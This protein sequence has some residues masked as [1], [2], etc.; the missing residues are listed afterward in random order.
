MGEILGFPAPGLAGYLLPPGYSFAA[1]P[2]TRAD[3]ADERAYQE[4]L[5][6]LVLYV[7]C[8]Y[9]G[10]HSHPESFTCPGCG[11]PLTL[12]R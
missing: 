2:I 4:Q 7:A 10:R 11:A 12:T 9:C 8:D 3:L 6:G 5:R 1:L